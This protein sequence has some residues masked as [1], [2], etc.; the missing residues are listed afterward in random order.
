[1]PLFIS[2]GLGLGLRLVSS[3]LSL[4]LVMLVLVLRIWSC[5]HYWC[6]VALVSHYCIG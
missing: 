6:S 4:G 2:G 3:A 1:M 5:L